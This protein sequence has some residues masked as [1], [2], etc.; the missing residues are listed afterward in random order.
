MA[1]LYSVLLTCLTPTT[2]ILVLLVVAVVFRRRTGLARMSAA[3]GLAILLVCGNGWVGGTFV[4]SLES[5]SSPLSPAA[6]GDAIVILSGGILPRT[7]PRTTVEVSDGDP[8]PLGGRRVRQERD[9]VGRAVR[10]TLGSSVEGHRLNT[11]A[12]SGM[13][14]RYARSSSRATVTE[15]TSGCRAKACSARSGEPV[16]AASMVS[17]STDLTW[18]MRPS[19]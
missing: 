13:R 19:W 17:R 8:N 10:R 16:T 14:S 12:T 7:S 6:S 18:A 2:P 5:A 11:A 1:F 15:S 9:L 4:R 3:A